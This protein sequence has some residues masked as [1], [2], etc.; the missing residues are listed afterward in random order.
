MMSEKQDNL[1]RLLMEIRLEALRKRCY[2]AMST[3]N[4]TVVAARKLGIEP[5][6]APWGNGG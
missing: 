1:T 5:G 3:W 6:Q 4:E 2:D